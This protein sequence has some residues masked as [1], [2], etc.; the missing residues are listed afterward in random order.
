MPYRLALMESKK[1]TGRESTVN[2]TSKR[3]MQRLK[4]HIEQLEN[5]V[6]QALEV[7]EAETGKLLNYRQLLKDSKYKKYW[8]T[9]SENE[10]VRLVNGVG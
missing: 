5:D 10:F 2:S 3:H 1:R 6:H 4:N 8:S 7:M 9:L